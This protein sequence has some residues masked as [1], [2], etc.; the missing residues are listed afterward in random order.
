MA[1][2]SQAHMFLGAIEI[3]GLKDGDRCRVLDTES[4]STPTWVKEIYDH[5]LACVECQNQG[6][7]WI[8]IDENSAGMCPLCLLKQYDEKVVM[9]EQRRPFVMF[10]QTA[11]NSGYCSWKDTTLSVVK[12][13]AYPERRVKTIVVMG[14]IVDVFGEQ[15]I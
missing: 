14:K 5:E 7:F 4:Y 6:A 8:E 15:D 2:H 9:E 11:M 1:E 3:Y 12:K 10:W 13:L